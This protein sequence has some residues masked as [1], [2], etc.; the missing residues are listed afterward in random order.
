MSPRSPA[1]V[2]ISRRPPS[3]ITLN[4]TFHG[5]VGGDALGTPAG[6]G[7]PGAAGE[8]PCFPLSELQVGGQQVTKRSDG[9]D[10]V[11]IYPRFLRL[12]GPLW[13]HI[14]VCCVRWVRCGN[15]P[16]LPASVWSVMGIYPRWR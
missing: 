15:I 5:A 1:H 13:K 8:V 3:P 12:F 6:G 4:P 9:W 11:G 2:G 14:H 16:A 10:V 7:P